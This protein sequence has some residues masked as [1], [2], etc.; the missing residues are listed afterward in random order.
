MKAAYADID[1]FL[2]ALRSFDGVFIVEGKKDVAALDGLG[3]RTVI[4]LDGPLFTVI[5]RVAAQWTRCAILTDLDA[6]GKKLYRE[7][8]I[9][10]QRHGVKID[11]SFRDFLFTTEVRHIEGLPAYILHKE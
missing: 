1:A 5:E 9:H 3:V 7:L 6:E 10:L 2:D 8:Y 11:D 4:Q